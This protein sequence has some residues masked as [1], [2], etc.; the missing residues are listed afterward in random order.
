MISVGLQPVGAATAGV[1]LDAVGGG[2]TLRLM[3]VGLIVAAVAA[4]F[5]PTLRSARGRR[6]E[7]QPATGVP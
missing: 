7:S 1:L 6:P 2:P 4:G 3:G 5:S